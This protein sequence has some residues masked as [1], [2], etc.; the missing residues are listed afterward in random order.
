MFIFSPIFTSQFQHLGSYTSQRF[1]Q[2]P[3][4]LYSQLAGKLVL[5]ATLCYYQLFT[6]I[7]MSVPYMYSTVSG[8]GA[9][10]VMLQ[11]AIRRG[12]Q[13]IL[14]STWNVIVASAM[15]HISLDYSSQISLQEPSE[16]RCAGFYPDTRYKLVIEVLNVDTGYNYT[17]ITF[18]IDSQQAFTV[19]IWS[20]N[21]NRTLSLSPASEDIT[22]PQLRKISENC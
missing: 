14:F 15:K 17:N 11:S 18:H 20:K 5:R 4:D 3:M 9:C 7:L 16:S 2:V 19:S 8:N 1:Y 6:P 21:S 10:W 13:Q 22:A 12:S